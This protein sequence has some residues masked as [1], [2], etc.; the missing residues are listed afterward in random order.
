MRELT[1]QLGREIGVG[2]NSHVYEIV[3]NPHL[4]LKTIGSVDYDPSFV[5]LDYQEAVRM[6]KR[7]ARI[8]EGVSLARILKVGMKNGFPG[9][10]MQRASGSELFR[11][12]M[13]YSAWHERVEQLEDA[14]QNQYDKLVADHIAILKAGL[15][16]DYKPSNFFYCQDN[17]FTFMDLVPSSLPQSLTNTLLYPTIHEDSVTEEDRAKRVTIKTKLHEAGDHPFF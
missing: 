14:P 5:D 17:G 6:K 11:K 12:G 3:G 7:Y 16:V 4:V 1:Y 8:P 9:V 2:G 13:T 15:C 10:V